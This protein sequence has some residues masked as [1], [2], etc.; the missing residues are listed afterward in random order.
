MYEHS[1]Q[2]SVD[3]LVEKFYFDEWIAKK[4]TLDELKKSD[5][6]GEEKLRLLESRDL[7]ELQITRGQ[8][9]LLKKAI[10]YLD[11][12]HPKK[13]HKDFRSQSKLHFLR[14]IQA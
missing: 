7:A 10:Q 3:C 13:R 5:L 9:K 4:E 12:A 8:H 2:F 11:G 6:D 1:E 14:R